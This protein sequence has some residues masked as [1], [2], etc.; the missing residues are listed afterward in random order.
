MTLRLKKVAA[1]NKI[2]PERTKSIELMLQSY[3]G[4]LEGDKRIE[5]IAD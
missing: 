1:G 3:S 5:R 4:I 2:Q